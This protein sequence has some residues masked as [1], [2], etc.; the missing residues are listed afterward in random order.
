M[1]K[2]LSISFLFTLLASGCSQDKITEQQQTF[3]NLPIVTVGFEE[4]TSRTY[5]SEGKRLRWTEGDQISFFYKS[6]LN[7]QYKFDGKTGA[8]AGTFSPIKQVVGTGSD[9]NRNYAVYPYDSNIEI[10]EDGI[11]TATLPSEQ[12]YAENSFGLGDNTMV[13]V[14]QDIEDTFLGFKNVGGYLKLHLYGDNVTIKTITLQGE[15]NEKIAGEATII[16][17]YNGE[18]TTEMS[19][20]ATNTIILNCSEGVKIGT[21]TET[22]TAF[23]LVVP[24]TTF[25]NGFTITVTDINNNVVTKSTSNNITIKR[26]LIQPMDAFKVEFEETIPIEKTALLL[27]DGNTFNT[28]V[29]TYLTDNSNLTKI[30]FVADSKTTSE[31][32]L[33]TDKNGSIAYLVSNGEWLEIHTSA[34]EFKAYW[35]SK[36]MFKGTTDDSPFRDITTIDFGDNFNTTEIVEIGEMFFNCTSLNTLDVSKFNTSNVVVMGDMFYNCSSLE[37]LDIRN[38]NTSKVTGMPALFAGCSKLS[39]I[40]IS[41]FNTSNVTSMHSMFKDC[42]SLTSIDIS[43]FETT[44]VTNMNN[45][46][47]GCKALT[48]LDLTNFNTSN[49][50]LTANMFAN[51]DNLVSIDVSKFDTSKVTEMSW[52]FMNCPKL[53]NLDLSN[54]TFAGSPKVDDMFFCRTR[55]DKLTVKVSEEGYNYLTEKVNEKNYDY[56]YWEMWK[57]T[58]TTNQ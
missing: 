4:S 47:N 3:A 41:N 36:Y 1:K 14:T 31:N 10:D 16:P 8:N 12:T 38:F 23:W 44:N 2:I 21:T 54:F 24:P 51:C 43:N 37:S 26:N 34:N 40:N 45:M 28:T 30:K 39:S 29:S 13:A 7:Y 25:E 17:V 35:D 6:A 42:E 19:N 55:T 57:I 20:N 56:N 27:P 52:M 32:I 18:P 48:S 53:N 5:M 9:L 22:A 33:V 58:L 50:G 11:I 46:F 15:S 49:L